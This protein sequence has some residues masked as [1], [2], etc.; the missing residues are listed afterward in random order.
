[1]SAMGDILA[2]NASTLSQLQLDHNQIGDDGL[3]HL[4]EGLKQ[5]RKLEALWLAENGLTSRS[6]VTLSEVLSGLSSLE[7]LSVSVLGD[8]SMEQLAH[9]MRTCT[10]LKL[11]LVRPARLSTRSVPVLHHLLSS[12]PS[13]TLNAFEDNFSEDV[14]KELF[15]CVGAHRINMY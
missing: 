2:N 8:D 13:L 14:K 4:L 10:R 12:I 15:R 3:D 6:D 1:M 11:L 9:G 5:C 7:Q